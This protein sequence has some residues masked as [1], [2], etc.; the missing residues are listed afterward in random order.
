ML[1]FI[2]SDL[3]NP[4]I[5]FLKKGHKRE[6]GM[7]SLTNLVK[8]G[9]IFVPSS[10]YSFLALL[11]FFL[12]ILSVP[13]FVILRIILTSCLLIFLWQK[14]IP[15]LILLFIRL[16]RIVNHF[17]IIMQIFLMEHYLHHYKY[18]CLNTV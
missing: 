8:T 3:F 14:Q 18:Y 2:Y 1:V 12:L 5:I 17:S 16:Y 4:D 6:V 7:R 10:P 11:L 15:Y 9:L 13:F